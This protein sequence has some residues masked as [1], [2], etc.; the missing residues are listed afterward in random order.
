[1]VNQTPDEPEQYVHVLV[2]PVALVVMVAIGFVRFGQLSAIVAR[3]QVA[4]IPTVLQINEACQLMVQAFALAMG[5][6]PGQ[7]VSLPS[8]ESASH[9]TVDAPSQP[10]ESQPVD[11]D[12]VDAVLNALD[13]ETAQE[14]ATAQPTAAAPILPNVDPDCLSLVQGFV[15]ESG[16]SADKLAASLLHQLN[17]ERAL[18][19]DPSQDRP[20]RPDRRD[21]SER[22]A[23]GERGGRGS[24]DDRG[25][26]AGTI[27]SFCGWSQ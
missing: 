6:E 22:G 21:R 9:Q 5:M 24:R 12:N 1:M 3:L 26:P 20:A 13:D 7:K 15:T 8:V 10:V 16:V 14:S 19:L 27:L 17:G 4:E 23:G 2:V 25:R 11:A 18:L